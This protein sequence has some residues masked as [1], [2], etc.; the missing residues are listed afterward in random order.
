MGGIPGGPK[1]WEW[2]DIEVVGPAPAPRT[3]HA[4]CLLG[5]GKTVLVQGGWDPQGEE[6]LV[7]KWMAVFPAIYNKRACAHHR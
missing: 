3:G 5:D 4:A 2:L 7:S 6:T 1:E